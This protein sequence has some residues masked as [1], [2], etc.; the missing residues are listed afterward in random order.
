MRRFGNLSAQLDEEL[1]SAGAVRCQAA[2]GSA[3]VCQTGDGFGGLAG[4][5]WPLGGSRA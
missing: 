4:P 3:E 5:S 2:H 1:G